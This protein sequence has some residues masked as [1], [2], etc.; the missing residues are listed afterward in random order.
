[1]TRADGEKRVA[2]AIVIGAGAAGLAAARTLARSAR[3]VIL[4]EARK[5]IGGRVLTV[6]RP[7]SPVPIE[8]GAEFVH[9]DVDATFAMLAAAGLSAIEIPDRHWLLRRGR[10]EVTGD[11][12]QRAL[13][14]RKLAPARG[15]RS[16][17]EVMRGRRIRPDVAAL[18]RGYVE[19]YHAARLERVSAR[20]LAD[21]ADTTD[22]P[23]RQ[24]RILGGYG[25]LLE[26]MR[27]ALDPELVTL[28]L[29]AAVTGVAWRRGRV[30]VASRSSFGRELPVSHAKRA[31]VTVPLGVL[32]APPGAPGA[33][34]F[35]P[36]L[37]GKRRSLERLEVGHV[38]KTVLAFRSRFW[39]RLELPGLR[40]E[41]LAGRDLDFVHRFGARV[42]TWWT[43]LP[44]LA[45]VLTAWAGG[46]AAE[47]LLSEDRPT[48]METIL[49]TLAEVL[50][51]RRREL[52]DQ[53]VGSWS[54]DW[55]ADPFS[56]GAYT[57][58]GVGGANAL[59]ELAKPVEDTLYFAG[60]ATDAKLTA[61][62]GGALAS[63]ERA[64]RAL[65]RA[66]GA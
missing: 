60:E 13:L 62:V 25:R 23:A 11:F 51:V 55:D 10:F 44:V 57:Y 58:A 33:V 42:P 49:A 52:D 16:L 65:L 48:R 8:L 35:E 2:D 63:G 47:S 7:Q 18:L 43:T 34:R 1:M 14:L 46:P 17:A 56:R 41:R 27:A 37:A 19:G 40:R 6:E 32:K 61:T 36:E 9:G 66:A 54:H 24:F 30:A 15:D 50:G 28:R 21:G 39:E 64:A 38:A 5:R 3:R 22:E 20:W 59:R 31:I 12:F 29:D 26:R 4:L 53:L 45:P